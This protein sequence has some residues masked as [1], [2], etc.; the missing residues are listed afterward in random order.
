MKSLFAWEALLCSLEIFYLSKEIFLETVFVLGCTT[1]T[2]VCVA[3]FSVSSSKAGCGPEDSLA[4]AGPAD[5]RAEAGCEQ[6]LH[7]AAGE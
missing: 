6:G 7:R 3:C 1:H 2:F 4:A 5:Q